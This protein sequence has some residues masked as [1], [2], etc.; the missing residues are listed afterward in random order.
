MA[1][2]VYAYAHASSGVILLRFSARTRAEPP[3]Q[4]LR[5]LDQ[6]KE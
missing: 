2:S 5:F 4:M 6:V 3:A 1:H